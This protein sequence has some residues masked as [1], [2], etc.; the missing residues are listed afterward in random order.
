ML[1]LKTIHGGAFVTSIYNKPTDSGH[2]LNAQS[3]CPERYKTSVIRS[4][5][6]RAYEVC[7]S[8]DLFHKQTNRTRQVLINNGYSNTR[9]NEEFNTYL[10]QQQDDKNKDRT[11]LEKT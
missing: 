6:P 5:I 1:M 8:W 4:N 7:P 3:E 10:N 9:I 2:C 11:M